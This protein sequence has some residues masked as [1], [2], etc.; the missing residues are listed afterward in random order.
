M[1]AKKNCPLMME[2]GQLT[3]ISEKV[4]KNIQNLTPSDIIV[5]IYILKNII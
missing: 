4:Y 5:L 3:A 2:V 1:I